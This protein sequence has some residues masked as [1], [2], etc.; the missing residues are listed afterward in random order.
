MKN[1][2]ELILPLK[3][4]N[5]EPTYPLAKTQTNDMISRMDPITIKSEKEEI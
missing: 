5:S 2:I 3:M 4:M 1:D